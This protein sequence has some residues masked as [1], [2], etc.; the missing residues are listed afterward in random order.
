MRKNPSDRYILTENVLGQ[1]L[2]A[3]ARAR[4]SR[5]ESWRSI[6]LAL[7][8]ATG[9]DVTPE[10]LRKWFGDMERPRKP[11]TETEVAS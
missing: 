4:V 9:I 2:R 10:T 5:G 3:W 1:N 8:D 7:R 11:T 6:S